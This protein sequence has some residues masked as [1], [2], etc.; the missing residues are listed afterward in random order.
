MNTMTSLYSCSQSKCSC[1]SHNLLQ[2][3]KVR[4]TE[5]DELAKC[6]YTTPTTVY[7]VLKKNVELHMRKTLLDVASVRAFSFLLWL[8]RHRWPNLCWCH[9]DFFSDDQMSPDQKL[10]NPDE[11]HKVWLKA[12][13]EIQ[14]VCLSKINSQ[15]RLWATESLVDP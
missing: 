10:K 2:I 14:W 7:H 4:T 13:E 15:L 1:E 12:P 5:E 11:D 6:C 3:C 9:S 8:N